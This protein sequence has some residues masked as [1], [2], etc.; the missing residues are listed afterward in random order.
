MKY[1]IALLLLLPLTTCSDDAI[2]SPDSPQAIL[3]TWQLTEVLADPGDGSGTYRPVE[4]DKIIIFESNGTYTSN[5]AICSFSITVEENVVGT[6]E[7]ISNSEFIINCP[8][9]NLANVTLTLENGIL[10]A[11]FPCIEPC[12]QKYIKID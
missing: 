6:Y 7:I 9:E 1:L 11:N 2:F 10:I 12:G 4:S 5:G 8:E 3:G